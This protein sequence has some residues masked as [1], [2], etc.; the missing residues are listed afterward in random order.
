MRNTEDKPAHNCG[1]QRDVQ[2]THGITDHLH[3]LQKMLPSQIL[4]GSDSRHFG[5][6]RLM[7]GVPDRMC[8]FGER[9]T[10]ILGEHRDLVIKH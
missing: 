9:T 1:S 7:P 2:G 5:L 8:S 6:S 10:P 3:S 4:S